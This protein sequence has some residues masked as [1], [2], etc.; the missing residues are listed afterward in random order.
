MKTLSIY[1]LGLLCVA[2][3]LYGRGAVT[4]IPLN[5]RPVKL[6]IGQNEKE[7]YLLSRQTPVK[8]Q[9]DGPGKLTVMSRLMFGPK[10]AES[11]KY[12][13]RLKDGQKTLKVHTTQTDKS[14]AGFKDSKEIPGKSRKFSLAIPEGSF[15]YE[16]YIEDTQLSAALRFSFQR[17]K[18]TGKKVAIEPLSYDRVVTLQI[19]E[20]LVAYYVSS[21][22]RSVQL[23]VVGP[24]RLEV[25]TRLNYDEK[26]KGA[27]KYTILIEENSRKIEQRSLQTTKS[28]GASYQ[29]WKD[30]V[31]GKAKSLFLNVPSGEHKYDIAL[32]ETLAKS[33]S[34]RFSL[35]Q[36]DL[37]NSQ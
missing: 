2:G 6:V 4:I 26:M 3:S 15:T 7:Y 22:E 23:R 8:L 13:L 33:V 25:S 34:L 10:A 21:K 30:V 1:F 29:E 37:K 24:T 32:D 19:A 20:N 31:P 28:V 27:Q 17:A 16:V 11:Q 36:K 5:A 14:D 9:L 12:T 18:E 35:P